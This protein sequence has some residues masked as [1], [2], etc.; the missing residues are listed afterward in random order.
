MGPGT[1]AMFFICFPGIQKMCVSQRQRGPDWVAGTSK[2][3]GAEATETAQPSKEQV[4]DPCLV[5]VR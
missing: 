4:N 2:S 3:S 5:N 1:T